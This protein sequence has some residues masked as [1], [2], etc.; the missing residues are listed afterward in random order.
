M[1]RHSNVI[2]CSP[3]G[4]IL[5]AAYQVGHKQ[6]RVRE[7]TIGGTYELPPPA[8]GIEPSP[9]EGIAQW[10]ANVKQ[11]AATSR[12]GSLRSGLVKAYLGCSPALVEELCAC[13]GLDPLARPDVLAPT[14]WAELNHHW[15]RWLQILHCVEGCSFASGRVRNSQ[16]YS[17][18]RTSTDREVYEEVQVD[19]EADIDAALLRRDLWQSVSSV[20][21]I[22][23]ALDAEYS[24]MVAVEKYNQLRQV[25][26]T[27]VKARVKKVHD[28]T[29][30]FEKR[31]VMS[32]ESEVPRQQADLIMAN[33]HLY[34]HRAETLEVQDWYGSEDG[35][36]SMVAI[37]IDPFKGPVAT[38]QVRQ[39]RAQH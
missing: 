14:Q 30:N 29:R 22:N 1:G 10:M 28:K 15:L 26:L 36:P 17:V 12:D 24:T 5:C 16:A 6:T 13:A 4:E 39:S 2:T 8:Q 7:V 23:A 33:V 9:E 27:K 35:E 18:L 32:D 34:T 19:D 38:A 21:P 20:S 31:M 11:A 37:P 25:L 3:D